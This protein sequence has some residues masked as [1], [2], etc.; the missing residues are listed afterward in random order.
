MTAIAMSGKRALVKERV[1]HEPHGKKSEYQQKLSSSPATRAASTWVLN[2]SS[3]R[4]T[5]AKEDSPAPTTAHA[6]MFGVRF[7]CG[8]CVRVNTFGY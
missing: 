4:I 7:V 8:K 1:C 5:L 2:T 6:C 3:R